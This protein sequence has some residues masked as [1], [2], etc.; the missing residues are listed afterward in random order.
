M[1][2]KGVVYHH[3]PVHLVVPFEHDD[4]RPD[5]FDT[6][7]RQKGHLKEAV[8]WF[9]EAGYNPIILSDN[10]ISYLVLKW[11]FRKSK[12]KVYFE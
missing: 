3:G 1:E 5:F 12:V 8:K 2:E 6:I 10:I 7:I 11:Y 9:E 4:D